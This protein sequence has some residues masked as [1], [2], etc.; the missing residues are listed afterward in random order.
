M[1]VKSHEIA[2]MMKVEILADIEAGV[3]PPSVHNFSEL[4]DYVDANCYGGAESLFEELCNAGSEDETVHP[5]TR[6]CEVINP[7]IAAVD[8]WL[9]AGKHRDQHV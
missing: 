2:E 4:H 3:V 6:L 5:F 9:V 7:A 1:M 8:E